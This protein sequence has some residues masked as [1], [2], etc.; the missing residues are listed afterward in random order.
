[1]EFCDLAFEFFSF[2]LVDI[3][4]LGLA[5]WE[6]ILIVIRGQYCVTDTGKGWD[7]FSDF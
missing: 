6:L 4:R 7:R 2:F 5:N 3:I 1:M